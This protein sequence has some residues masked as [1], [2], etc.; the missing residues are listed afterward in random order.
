MKNILGIV[1]ITMFYCN[2]SNALDIILACDV[3]EVDDN[4]YAKNLGVP[5]QIKYFRIRESEVGS[6]WDQYNNIFINWHYTI[7]I[8]EKYIKFY[9]WPGSNSNTND[10]QV[11]DRETGIMVTQNYVNHN[12][13]YNALCNKI[14]S[15]AL[16]I[17]KA[18][19]KF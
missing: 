16:P 15:S 13:K 17:K 8:D 11:I 6:N 2:I 19:K 14:E 10:M 9:K 7:S 18:K 4:T 1:F 5:G 12:K 3:K